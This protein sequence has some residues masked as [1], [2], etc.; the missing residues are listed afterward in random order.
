[1]HR[2]SLFPLAAGIVGLVAI[3]PVLAAEPS[4]AAAGSAPEKATTTSSAAATSSTMSGSDSG[5]GSNSGTDSSTDTS[6]DSSSNSSTDSS[7]TSSTATTGKGN[8]TPTTASTAPGNRTSSTTCDPPETEQNP[9]PQI[10]DS[11]QSYGAGDA[12]S[13][14]VE[15][16]SD[17]ELR[18]AKASA[19][20]G[21]SQQVTAPSGPRVTV[22]FS[23]PGQSPSL[24]RF[25]ASMDQK[26]T[27]I[28]VRV[29]SCG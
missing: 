19:N 8:A 10:G 18:I 22:K 7:T 5:S 14:D 4:R 2:R 17:T 24:I 21:W 29:T 28:H 23:R 25:A 11:P 12:G 26:G 27:M 20:D 15:R 9:A 6:T 1:M 3:S 16:L 13:V